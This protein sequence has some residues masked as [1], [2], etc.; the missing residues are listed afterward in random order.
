MDL[1]GSTGRVLLLEELLIPPPY[2][3]D[4]LFVN[5][6]LFRVGVAFVPTNI[7]PAVSAK[8]L[9]NVQLVTTGLPD[10]MYIP[11]PT[12][13][14]NLLFLNMQLSRVG[15]LAEMYI[16]LPSYDSPF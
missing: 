4:E 9:S 5:V 14:Q 12:P 6:Q 7:P 3:S 15:L 13:A 11:P 10:M 16:P 1:E 2:S 8:L